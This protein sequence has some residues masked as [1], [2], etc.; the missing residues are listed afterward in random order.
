MAPQTNL[1][2]AQARLLSEH[3]AKKGL[4]IQKTFLFGSQLTE[5][6]TKDSDIDVA[7]VS[8]QFSG[9]RFK[10]AVFLIP[11]LT[12]LP[13]QIEIH[14]YSTKDFDDPENWFAEHIR[15]TGL[16]IK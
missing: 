3:L 14:P 9:I 1:A 8:D 13:N 4:K 12:G 6:A 11:L 5:A 10:D 7:V 2:I 15:A 16:E